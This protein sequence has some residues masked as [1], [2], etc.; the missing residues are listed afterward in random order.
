MQDSKMPV[1]GF[2]VHGLI[3]LGGSGHWVRVAT[4]HAWLH[5]LKPKGVCGQHMMC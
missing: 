2:L 4:W 3:G 5:S 1:L